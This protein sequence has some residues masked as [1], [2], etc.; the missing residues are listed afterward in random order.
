MNLKD[1]LYNELS[2]ATVKNYLYE[3]E[4]FR[5]HYKNS[6]K[7]KYK[8]IMDYVELLRKTYNPQSIKR[9]VYAIKK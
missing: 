4:K 1:Y 7:L 9:T 3:I 5:K 6:G 8:N 2:E